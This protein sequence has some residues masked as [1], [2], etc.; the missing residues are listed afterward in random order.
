MHV[1]DDDAQRRDRTGERVGP[2][3]ALEAGPDH[4]GGRRRH[5]AERE[6]QDGEGGL[7]GRT[8]RTGVPGQPQRQRV[9]VR[10]VRA[11]H[12]A[13][14]R[15]VGQAG[16]VQQRVGH[17]QPDRQLVELASSPTGSAAASRRSNQAETAAT[18]WGGQPP[19]SSGRAGC[20]PVSSSGPAAASGSVSCTRSCTV[21]PTARR[22]QGHRPGC[23]D[24]DCARCTRCGGAQR[25]PLPSRT[26]RPE[27]PR[28]RTQ[29]AEAPHAPH[30]ARPSRPRPRRPRA[31]RV[32]CPHGV[33][34]C[35]A[36]R[37]AGGPD[38]DRAA[39]VPETSAGAA[40]SVRPDRFQR[41]ALAGGAAAS[42]QIAGQA[43]ARV[44]APTTME[45]ARARRRPAAL[46][47]AAVQRHGA[48][49][50]GAAPGD[51]DL[52]RP[53]G[54]RPRRHRP[55]R[56]RLARPA[57]L[58]ALAARQLVRRPVL[59]PR[60]RGLPQLLGPG[61]AHQPA[62]RVRR[63]RLPWPGRGGQRAGR[64]CARPHRG[65]D[66][67]RPVR[68]QPA[69][70]L[71]PRAGE[72]P[73]VR[74]LL[75]LR[76]RH[77]GQGRADQPRRPGLRGRPVDPPGAHRRHRQA[78]PRHGGEVDR[79]RRALRLGPLLPARLAA[80]LHDRLA[81]AQRQRARPPRRR[82]RV[83]R[84]PH[85]PRQERRRHRRARRRGHGAEGDRLHRHPGPGRRL[86]RRRLRRARDRP[87]VQRRP[88]LQR[89][90]DQ[91]L[92]RQPQR[93]HVRRA[94]QRLVDHG[95]RR[96][97][98]EGRPPAAQR[99][100]LLAA[101]P[102]G[103]RPLH[104]VRPARPGRAADGRPA[105]LRRLELV[106]AVVPRRTAPAHHAGRELHRRGHPRR[107][108]GAP[109]GARGLRHGAGLRRPSARS[110]TPASR[111][112]SAAPSPAPTSPLS[113][114]WTRPGP[115]A[116]SARPGAA[117]RPPTRASRPA[118]ATRRRSS[119]PAPRTRSRSGRRSPSRAARPT[120]T[121]T[122]SPTCGSRTTSVARTA[123]G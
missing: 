122:S 45:P 37:R 41:W 82:Q 116:A 5:H 49:A 106:R 114:W 109:D 118:P 102:A 110:T 99:P 84:R 17:V 83:R 2:A 65:L 68:R 120:P 85:R 100:V 38:L 80:V 113:A 55:A 72:R 60:P 103:D 44:G 31:R 35:G 59:H 42:L 58:R 23:A 7:P 107:S 97:L 112:S 29:D 74:R 4:A 101:Q 78:Q 12:E 11:V 21:P 89:R 8:G 87:P 34:V 18:T 26:S 121:P 94:R 61:P 51:L 96:H 22:Q 9:R 30:P 64:G 88:H 28:T 50:R 92:R 76:E 6:H 81:A 20:A 33:R 62:R 25:H 10:L 86:L 105:R 32:R 108:P 46:H 66:R 91:L 39:T 16:G 111:C 40:R 3:V 52:G 54:R 75:R 27:R 53:R 123:P 63:R 69:A 47:G 15:E 48:R 70:H 56:H 73:L 104:L 79:E 67:R 57:R 24:L 13:G 117:A 115:P 119:T 43:P 1:R 36:L 71:P 98:R 90:G 14:G 95:V 93:R 19:R 77:R